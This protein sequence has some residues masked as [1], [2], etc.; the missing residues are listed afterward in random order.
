MSDQFLLITAVAVLIAVFHMVA[1]DHWLPITV[2]S[3]T[4]RFSRAK[5]YSITALIALLHGVL[6]SAI[7]MA[8]L[9]VG[10]VFLSKFVQ[11][12]TFT[13]LILLLI[14]G[15]YFVIN[16]FMERNSGSFAGN[17]SLAVGVLPDFA[18]MPL[19]LS[20]SAL[21]LYQIGLIVTIFISAGIA[22]LLA[23]VT[24][25]SFA[26]G[27]ALRRLSP[28]YFDYIIGII[29]FVTAASVYFEII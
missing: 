28:A 20:G 3:E 17:T 19:L 12:I 10:L 27:F 8:V 21:S 6:S 16:G 18:I 4:R 23:V 7:A 2:I 14:V 24:V 5:K 1:P 26:T 22:S 29:L 25:A 11:Y 15:A 9:Y 13:G